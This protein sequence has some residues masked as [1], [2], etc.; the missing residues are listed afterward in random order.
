M[1]LPNGVH[2][3][4]M[5][6]SKYVQSAVAIVK[7]Y[8]RKHFPTQQWLQRA[9]GPFPVDYAPEIDTTPTLNASQATFY[10][11]Q[12]GVLR[13]CVELSQVD[14]ITEVSELASYLAMP[15]EGHLEAVFHLFANLEKK[16]NARIV[17]DPTYPDIDMTSFKECNWKHY[18]GDVVEAIP[19][20]APE[21]RV[22]NV[23]L[24]MFVDSDHAGDKRTRRSRT[25]FIL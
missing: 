20:N 25:G 4:V 22:K 8:H 19:P 24:R 13:W 18:Y 17:F 12:I 3:W 9:K 21:P 23:D 5:S 6:S 10:Q 2:A 7:G 11:T 1:T 16:H 15:R 14:I